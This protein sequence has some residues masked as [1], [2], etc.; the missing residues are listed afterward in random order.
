MYLPRLIISG[1]HS[2]VGKT[3]VATALM[4]ALAGSGLKVQPFKVGP[5]YIDP[6]YH[7]AATGH[8]SRNL[9]PWLLGEDGVREMFMRSAAGADISIIEGVMGLYDGRGSGDEGST[10][11]V[12]RLL[13]AP[14]VLVL[15]A[16]SMARSAAAMV[17]GYKKFDPEVNLCAVILNNLRSERHFLFLKEG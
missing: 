11:H 17:L 4:R 13:N 3:T 5:D 10:A 6:G 15:D 1:V 16:R 8:N 14:V 9:D 2:G 7:T 12:A